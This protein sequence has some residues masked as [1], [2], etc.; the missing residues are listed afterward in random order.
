MKNKFDE[1]QPTGLTCPNCGPA[2]ALEIKTN[3]HT[4]RQFLGCSNYPACRYTC[5]IPEEWKLRMAG[6]QELFPP[7]SPTL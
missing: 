1:S 3:S 2:V 7:E 4:G 5:D 6:Q